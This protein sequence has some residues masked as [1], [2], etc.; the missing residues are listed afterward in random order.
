MNHRF[1]SRMLAVILLFWIATALGSAGR[2]KGT[3]DMGAV[4]CSGAPAD[5]GGPIMLTSDPSG[6]SLRG[7][8][9]A[10]CLAIRKAVYGTY[11]QP[12]AT[13]AAYRS[14]PTGWEGSQRIRLTPS[15]KWVTS[16]MW[17]SD[18]TLVL[19]DA[20]TS[21]LLRYSS[22][23]TLLGSVSKLVARPSASFRPFR[24][25]MTDRGALLQIEDGAFVR[26]NE[27]LETSA[28]VKPMQ[29][30]FSPS[31]KSLPA[32]YD[33]TTV[34]DQIYLFGD[35]QLPDG[36]WTSGL[37][38]RALSSQ[39]RLEMLYGMEVTD[40]YRK[41]YLLGNP[42]LATVDGTAYFLRM[43]RLTT[44]LEVQMDEK[45]RQLGS[46][47]YGIGSISLPA[48][49]GLRSASAVFH[50]LEA[51]D[52]PVGLYGQGKFLYVLSRRPDRGGTQWTLIKI[53]PKRDRIIARIALPSSA[54]HLAVVPGPKHWA[55][56][57]KGPVEALGIQV[58]SSVLLLPTA[59]LQESEHRESPRAMLR[60]VMGP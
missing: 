39:G 45:L 57:E 52:I 5:C 47:Q 20:L 11:R 27:R 36:R 14:A 56:L 30:D 26:L 25:R 17:N 7:S 33:W 9:A 6:R 46:F 42:F 51:A 35:L 13:V 53:D 34:R 40:P 24:L 60:M 50:A 43:D 23:G 10:G 41:F 22:Q 19:V 49:G 37:F 55:F 8:E 21:R 54:N 32:V 59:S 38:L 12:R 58:L 4:S 15:P 48:Q 18:G 2:L 3:L 28:S 1:V 16:G 44:I 29:A 31:T